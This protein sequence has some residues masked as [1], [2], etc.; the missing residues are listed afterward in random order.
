MKTSKKQERLKTMSNLDYRFNIDSKVVVTRQPDGV[1]DEDMIGLTGKIVDIDPDWHFPYEV[2]FDDGKDREACLFDKDSIELVKEE[3]VKV[4]DVPPASK[5][6][7][8]HDMDGAGG[9]SKNVSVIDLEKGVNRLN[10][11]TTEIDDMIFH[12]NH[13][14][15]SQLIFDIHDR[16]FRWYFDKYIE[17]FDVGFKMKEN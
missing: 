3:Y 2:S 17:K 7:Y 15:P 5:L 6:M 13:N 11:R 4:K 12:I 1:Y 8:I 16:K 14:K 10:M 9:N